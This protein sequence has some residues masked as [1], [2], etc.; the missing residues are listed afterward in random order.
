[1]SRLPEQSQYHGR[2]PR[3]DERDATLYLHRQRGEHRQDGRRTA[4]C[5]RQGNLFQILRDLHDFILDLS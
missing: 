3:G 2:R 4:L 1:M 5:R